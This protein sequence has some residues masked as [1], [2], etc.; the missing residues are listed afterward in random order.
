MTITSKLIHNMMEYFAGDAKRINHFIKVYGFAKTFG[1]LEGLD[2]KQQLVLETA[3]ITHDIGI[4]NSE[5]KYRSSAGYYQEIEGPSEAKILLESMEYSQELMDEVCFIIGHHHTYSAINSLTFQLLV[6]ADFLVNVVED[7]V[8]L[9]GI[10]SV[11]QKVFKSYWGKI[12]LS[13]L[14]FEK[15]KL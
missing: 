6:E 12:F 9:E 4:K 8:S 14:C 5:I 3:A 10:H 15:G 2:D 11:E 1:E 7:E 13:N